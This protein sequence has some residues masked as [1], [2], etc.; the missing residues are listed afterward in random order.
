MT[1]STR[2][3]R[4]RSQIMRIV[5]TSPHLNVTQIAATV[6][7]HPSTVQKHL[8]GERVTVRSPPAVVQRRG[9]RRSRQTSA[10]RR[11][12]GRSDPSAASCRGRLS[13]GASLSSQTGRPRRRCLAVPQRA[14]PIF[15]GAGQ[16]CDE[17][18]HSA[19]TVRTISRR[20]RKRRAVRSH[21]EPGMPDV[22]AFTALQRPRQAGPG[23]GRRRRRHTRRDASRP[24]PRPGMDQRRCAR[25][26]G[27][28][29][30]PAR[31]RTR[32]PGRR[33]PLQGVRDD[34]GAV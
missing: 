10:R 5:R 28:Q 17:S 32:W 9:D 11:S 7:C 8:R 18:A 14:E 2:S 31:I 29:P 1:T 13:G 21:R 24:D 6:G 19:H 20:R 22:A 27:R 23:C 3:Q 15:G 12:R 25:S 30:E 33:H 16:R 26:G 34:R 4:L